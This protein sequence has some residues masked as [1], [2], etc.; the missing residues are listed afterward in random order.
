VADGAGRLEM[1]AP[2][3]FRSAHLPRSLR[4][5]SADMAVTWSL[6]ASGAE[7]GAYL[8][9]LGRRLPDVGTY[10]ARL[11]IAGDGGVVLGLD[12]ISTDGE[13]TDVVAPV[14]VPELTYTAGPAA[15]AAAGDRHRPDAAGRGRLRAAELPV[16]DGDACAG[17]RGRPRVRG[18]VA[19]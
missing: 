3:S 8:Y 4:S 18:A 13:E 5:A 10:R 14:G 17:H 11:R 7:G 9:A 6:D 16:R 12:R 15:P 2:G 19:S 1:P